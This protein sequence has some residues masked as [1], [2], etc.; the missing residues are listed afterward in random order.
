MKSNGINQSSQKLYGTHTHFEWFLCAEAHVL[1]GPFA[2]FVGSRV[3]KYHSVLG[4]EGGLFKGKKVIKIYKEMFCLNG[5]KIAP[6]V[7]RTF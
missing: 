4:E 6:R 3:G 2:P 5:V 7:T 1:F